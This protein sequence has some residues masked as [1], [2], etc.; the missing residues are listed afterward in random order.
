M[1]IIPVWRQPRSAFQRLPLLSEEEN[2]PRRICSA[3]KR[4]SHAK[5]VLVVVSA[6]ALAK[7]IAAKGHELAV[8]ESLQGVLYRRLAR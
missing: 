3:I 2:I 4:Y 6:V 5:N 8:N 7:L 1:K